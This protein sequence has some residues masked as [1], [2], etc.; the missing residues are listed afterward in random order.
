MQFACP[1]HLA[2]V[3]RLIRLRSDQGRISRGTRRPKKMGR[4]PLR[5]DM[6]RQS[7]C[8]SE[9]TSLSIQRVKLSGASSRRQPH[10]A[11]L[12]KYG[13][14]V[15]PC[16]LLRR[17]EKHQTRQ[18]ENGPHGPTRPVPHP[19]PAITGGLRQSD[20]FSGRYDGTNEF[21]GRRRRATAAS[22]GH[23][24]CACEPR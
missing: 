3:S 24:A 12:W 6:L 11:L 17:G 15:G 13:T 16:F 4:R 22:S 20:V 23:A 5:E 18:E 7:L 14:R 9:P 21:L 10:S 8:R 19:S 2:T 1:E